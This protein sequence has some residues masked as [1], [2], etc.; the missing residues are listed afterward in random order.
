MPGKS[1]HGRGKRPHHSKKSKAIR[2]QVNAPLQQP[3]DV[4]PKPV[5]PVKAESVPKPAAPPDAAVMP[6][7]PYVVEELK[8]I[9]ILAG[10]IIVALI[11]LAIILG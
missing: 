8:R 3:A 6:R 4:A 10:I 2:R 9:G 5:A 7:N 1:R 11:M